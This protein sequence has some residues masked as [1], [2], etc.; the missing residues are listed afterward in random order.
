VY[1]IIYIRILIQITRKCTTLVDDKKNFFC[2]LQNR[3]I[4]LNIIE[5]FQNTKNK[6]EK[7]I[8]RIEKLL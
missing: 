3:I 7:L 2:K 1:N 4:V 8:K 6:R 5:L